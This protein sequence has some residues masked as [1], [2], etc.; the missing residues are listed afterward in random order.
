[1]VMVQPTQ[2]DH[3]T[4]QLSREPIKSLEKPSM[5]KRNEWMDGQ[6]DGP[7]DYTQWFRLFNGQGAGFRENNK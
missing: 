7:T 2:H 4:K 6:I 1:M 5:K 3:Y